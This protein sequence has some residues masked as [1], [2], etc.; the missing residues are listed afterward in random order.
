MLTI[1][2]AADALITELAI[3]TAFIVLEVDAYKETR[4]EEEEMTLDVLKA[5]RPAT[6]EDEEVFKGFCPPALAGIMEE[7]EIR[8]EPVLLL[9]L[10]LLVVVV[11]VDD[12]VEATVS[13]SL[14]VADC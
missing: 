14:V 9:P 11:V 2:E 3:A 10:L 4:P 1:G 12:I 7:V 6:T 13:C 8:I 5:V